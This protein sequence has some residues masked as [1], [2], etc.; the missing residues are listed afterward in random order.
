M[1]GVFISKKKKSNWVID[2]ERKDYDASEV[3]TRV[4]LENHL[5]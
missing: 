2:C 1:I 3:L 4:G 5:S